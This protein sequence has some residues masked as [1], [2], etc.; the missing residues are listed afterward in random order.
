MTE[1]KLIMEIFG[2]EG[3][4]LEHSEHELEPVSQERIDEMVKMINNG[5][6]AYLAAA[7][8]RNMDND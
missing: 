2:V 5:S 4:L 7:T 1:P 8:T 3:E 6:P